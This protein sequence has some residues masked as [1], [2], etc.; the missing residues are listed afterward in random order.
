M[1]PSSYAADKKGKSGIKRII[2]A[3][4]Y[5]KD[6]LAAAYRYESA[7]RQVLW[8]NLILIVL[9]FILNFDSATKMLLIIASFVSLITELFNTA[10]EAAVDH[11]STEKHEL[12]KRAKDAGSAAQLLALTMLGIVW[13]IALWHGYV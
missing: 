6:G 11:T 9:T 12:A 10:V 5:S 13:A 3:F 7:F 8:L 4:G 1:K 2:N